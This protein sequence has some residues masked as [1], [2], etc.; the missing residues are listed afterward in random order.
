MREIPIKQAQAV[1]KQ[2]IKGR[3]NQKIVLLTKKKDRSLIVVVQDKKLILTEQG[4][5]NGA[6]TYQIGDTQGK[7]ELTSAFKREF[8]RSHQLYMSQVKE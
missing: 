5:V 4:Y 2:A 7:H 1:L 8:L 3:I 6:C